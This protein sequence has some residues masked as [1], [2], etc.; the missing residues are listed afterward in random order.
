M[1]PQERRYWTTAWVTDSAVAVV[2]FLVQPCRTSATD[3]SFKTSN[4]TP[5]ATASPIHVATYAGSDKVPW[6]GGSSAVGGD[7]IP[8]MTRAAPSA[9]PSTSMMRIPPLLVAAREKSYCVRTTPA[10]RCR[11]SG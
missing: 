1:Y 11:T 5:A 10:A 6:A 3:A 7:A 2:P 4:V 9:R 8:V